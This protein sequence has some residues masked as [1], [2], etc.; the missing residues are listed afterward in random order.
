MYTYIYIYNS[1]NA[2]HLIFYSFPLGLHFMLFTTN[3]YL[4]YSTKMANMHIILTKLVNVTDFKI[5]R[6]VT[7]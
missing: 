4:T 5:R 2:V 7:R 3:T 1:P 6:H